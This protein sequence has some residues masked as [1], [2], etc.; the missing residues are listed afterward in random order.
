[1]LGNI[2]KKIGRV[3]EANGYRILIISGKTEFYPAKVH[4]KSGRDCKMA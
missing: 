3:A 1:M 4:H 2:A